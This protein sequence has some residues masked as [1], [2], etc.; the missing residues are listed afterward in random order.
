MQTVD[1][2][3]PSRAGIG[4]GRGLVHGCGRGLNGDWQNESIF[5]ER[6]RCWVDLLWVRGSC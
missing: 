5:Q 1:R 6:T 3:V 4:L 2:V